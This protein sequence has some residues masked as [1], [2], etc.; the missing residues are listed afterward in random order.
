MTTT[1][2]KGISPVRGEVWYVNF[3]PSVGAEQ[4][5]LRPAVVANVSEVGTTPC[6]SLFH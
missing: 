1:P 5:K 6:V 3:D 4:T 2:N